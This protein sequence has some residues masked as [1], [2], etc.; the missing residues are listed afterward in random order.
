MNRIEAGKTSNGHSKGFESST[1]ST[2]TRAKITI[3]T[4]MTTSASVA[5]SCP[6]PSTFIQL[7]S[8]AS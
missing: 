2:T 6:T 3:R 7:G 4:T 8:D 1:V 5:L